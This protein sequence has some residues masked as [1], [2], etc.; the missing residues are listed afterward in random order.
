[1]QVVELLADLHD[2][3]GLSYIFT[4]HDLSI[5]RNLAEHIMVMKS[6]SIVEEQPT[7]ALFRTPREDYGASCSTP[8]P[9]PKWQAAG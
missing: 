1:M 4:T 8:A 9:E 7:E 5:V 2:R 6:G 3:L